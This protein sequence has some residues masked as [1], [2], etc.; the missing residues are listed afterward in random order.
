[1]VKA[2]KKSIRDYW[3]RFPCIP[4]GLSS[5]QATAVRYHLEPMIPGFAQFSNYRNKLVLE[6]GC[7]AGTDFVQFVQ[8][9]A[10]AIGIDASLESLQICKTR[11]RG[12]SL[13]A[14]LIL[15]DAEN[16]P[17]RSAIFDLVYS[18]GVLHHV[19]NTQAA[20]HQVY[21]VL[22]N[23]GELKVMLY[24][25]T[26]LITLHLMFRKCYLRG[27]FES[28]DSFLSKYQESPGTKAYSVN[29]A[30]RMF[31]RFRNVVANPT[32]TSYDLTKLFSFLYFSPHIVFPARL[33]AIINRFGWFMLITAV[34]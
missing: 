14:S 6:V 23:D 19:A 30:K 21:R 11:L 12:K 5:D 8:Q 7:G 16:L 31:S 13:V 29:Q 1:M 26:S 24:H 28:L 33:K 2:S 10:Q 34:K 9:S 3:N 25:R 32:I 18:F 17:F 27:H 4:K 22:R 20:I 15:G